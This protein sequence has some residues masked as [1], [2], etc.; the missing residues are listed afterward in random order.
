MQEKPTDTVSRIGII[1]DV[2]AEDE[3]LRL[4]LA[5]L[6]QAG[7]DT[8]I[9]TGDIADGK[10]DIDRCVASLLEYG[11][12]TVRGNHDRWV[13]ENKARH[14]PNAH[15]ADELSAATL[16]FLGKLPQQIRVPT[17]MGDLLLCHGVGDNDLQKIWPGTQRMPAER[18]A[19]LDRIIEDD[20]TQIMVNGHVHYRTLIHFEKLLLINAG[21]LRPDHHPGFTILD[22]AARKIDGFEF[23]KQI[24]HVRTHSLDPQPET[25][26]FLNT[27]H[28]N[29]DWQPVTLYA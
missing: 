13:L 11:V 8:I 27:Q 23:D 20:A 5:F 26:V 29:G 21:T 22:I 12:R 17:Q 3:H 2:H 9:C 10:G 1:G 14:V 16:A 24:V 19:K 15:L 4:A 7:V 18:S 28:F 25:Q 6:T